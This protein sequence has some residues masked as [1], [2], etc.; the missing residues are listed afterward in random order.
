MYVCITCTLISDFLKKRHPS[1]SSSSQ[2]NQLPTLGASDVDAPIRATTAASPASPVAAA[3]AA[4]AAA[5]PTSADLPPSGTRLRSLLVASSS[6]SRLAKAKGAPLR[7]L[8]RTLSWTCHQVARDPLDSPFLCTYCI[9]L[10]CCL[11]I[12]VLLD[13]L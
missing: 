12:N 2:G 5:A 1:T 13:L 3:A 11:T 6:P 8:R 4:A 7:T 9:Y 10:L